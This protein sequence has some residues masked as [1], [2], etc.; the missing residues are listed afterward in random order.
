MKSSHGEIQEQLQ[1]ENPLP[2]IFKKKTNHQVRQ[3][4]VANRLKKLLD[5][6]VA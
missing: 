2:D 6:R 3:W 1:R 5:L 4:S